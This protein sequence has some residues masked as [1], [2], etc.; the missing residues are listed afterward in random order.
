MN[1]GRKENPILIILRF[2]GARLLSDYL[3]QKLGN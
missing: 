2:G 3:N 1:Y